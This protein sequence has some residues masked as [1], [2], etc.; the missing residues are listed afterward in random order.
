[1]NLNEGWQA[2]VTGVWR[3]LLTIHLTAMML[4]RQFLPSRVKSQASSSFLSMQDI[5]SA[6]RA[7][8]AINLVKAKFHYAI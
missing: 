8:E 7:L 2:D 1:M 5:A 4:L 3:P 6:H